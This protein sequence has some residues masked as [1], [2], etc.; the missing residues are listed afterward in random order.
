MPSGK[1]VPLRVATLDERSIGPAT[2][3]AKAPPPL[4]TAERRAAG[5]LPGPHPA[6]VITIV[7]AA[8]PAPSIAPAWAS[9]SPATSF[10]PSATSLSPSGTTE[11]LT[12]LSPV[13]TDDET[14]ERS[15]ARL[16]AMRARKRK[17]AAGAF[18]AVSLAALVVVVIAPRSIQDAQRIAKGIVGDDSASSTSAVASSSTSRPDSIDPA[19]PMAAGKEPTP[20]AM[21][22]GEA[23]SRTEQAI[24]ATPTNAATPI[25]AA[26]PG[27]VKSG[28]A[29]TVAAPASEKPAAQ[30][31]ADSE[32]PATTG[33]VVRPLLE[34]ANQRGGKLTDP[35]LMAALE[36]AAPKLDQCY[37]QA[38][39]KKPRLKGRLILAWTVRPNGKVAGA[40]KQGGT[41]KD[42]DLTRCTVDVISGIRFPKPKKQ[43]VL[44]RLPL[45]Y[46]KS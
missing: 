13:V 24:P 31:Q 34:Q 42:A 43:A 14:L 21:M 32:K 40:K 22:E 28:S 3:N 7:Q 27:G 36:K 44:I 2:L 35:Q 20:R 39:E 45:E 1:P 4:R 15:R 18:A 5:Q 29:E 12:S 16:S 38:L 23:P 33:P 17:V 6:P 37:A 11:P 25:P 9:A 10:T 8:Q 46:R 41:I 19:Q 30:P 26:E